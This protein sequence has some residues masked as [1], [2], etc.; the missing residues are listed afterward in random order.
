MDTSCKSLIV[1]GMIDSPLKLQLFLLFYRHPGLCR[2]V[3][4]VIEWLH[5][6]PWAIEESLEAL[7]TSG[8]ITRSEKQGRA[9]YCL[10]VNT[11]LW[12]RLNRLVN[13]Y[14]D[15]LQRDEV[16]ALVRQADRERQ[17]RALTAAVHEGSY[18][19]W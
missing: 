14:D 3:R 19:V 5:E 6:S 12:P 2:E 16:Y 1:V 17:F 7:A 13:C 18:A 15:P 11:A 9:I 10:D 4:C 8:L